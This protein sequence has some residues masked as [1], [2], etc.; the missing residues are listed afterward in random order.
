M[1]CAFLRRTFT[2]SNSARFPL[3]PAKKI[4]HGFEQMDKKHI[5]RG[6][7]CVCMSCVFLR[8]TFIISNSL[9]KWMRTVYLQVV[10]VFTCLVLLLE[11]LSFV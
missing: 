6:G 4:T 1:S 8:R 3:K 5:P 10:V 11:E 7:C 2:I 9:S